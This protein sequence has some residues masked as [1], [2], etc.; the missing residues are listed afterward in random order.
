MPL[1]LQYEL[2]NSWN[3]SESMCDL[4]V[5]FDVTCCTSS[6]LNLC[7]ISIGESI[8]SGAVHVTQLTNALLPDPDRYLAITRPLTYGVRRTTKRILFFIAMVWIASCLISI[9][10][11]MLLGNE[12]G[13]SEAPT[14]EVSQNLGYQLYA[15]LGAFY[16]PLTVMIVMYYK[17][18]GAAKRV[19]EAELRDQRPSSCSGTSGSGGTG[20]TGQTTIALLRHRGSQSS[21]ASCTVNWKSSRSVVIDEFAPDL[22]FQAQQA[23]AA[24]A[25]AN[26]LQ[27][28]ASSS[29]GS[30]PGV[31]RRQSV[32]EMVTPTQASSV[33]GAATPYYYNH[34][35]HHHS[36]LTHL[37]DVESDHQL[38]HIQPYLTVEPEV[39]PVNGNRKR[40][41][42]NV[43]FNQNGGQSHRNG[44]SGGSSEQSSLYDGNETLCGCC[45]G[46]K[47]H[48]APPSSLHTS[49]NKS[50]DANNNAKISKKSNKKCKSK[51][52]KKCRGKKAVS[53]DD[54]TQEVSST[55][56]IAGL[57]PVPT[58]RANGIMATPM[59]T[60]SSCNCICETSAHVLKQAKRNSN[61]STSTEHT[62]GGRHIIR[63]L[64][65]F[66]IKRK[67]STTTTTNGGNGTSQGT[68]SHSSYKR[69]TSNALRERKASFTL[70]KSRL[71]CWSPPFEQP[72]SSPRPELF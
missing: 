46:G 4:W 43:H 39:E 56:V 18:Y 27:I 53:L 44:S 58:S 63:S 3:L 6:I 8:H 26:S 52:S 38:Q 29:C 12:H 32:E 41:M 14:C 36:Q 13:S 35:S 24:A 51:T 64:R 5:S 61:S 10:P 67:Q 17:I 54:S 30:T 2:T 49:G 9:P 68:T 1:A 42:V 19:V 71:A 69:R 47:S 60:S 21:A 62:S 16:I 50:P 31:L 22:A 59:P 45:C 11:V 55:T 33:G 65:R 34:N 48:A 66:S 72:K 23:Q 40:N 20:N 25:S 7:T 15:T 70:G 28:P 37:G 57:N